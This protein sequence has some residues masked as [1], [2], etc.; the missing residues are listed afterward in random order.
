VVVAAVCVA[1]QALSLALERD[2]PVTPEALRRVPSGRL[3]PEPL[4]YGGGL[5]VRAAVSRKEDLEDAARRPGFLTR[6]F[7]ALDPT[8]F[9]DTGCGSRRNTTQAAS[10]GEPP[11]HTRLGTIPRCNNPGPLWA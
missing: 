2:D 1:G 11:S 3:P 8:S 4:R 9:V 6:A 10:A 7:A 5:V